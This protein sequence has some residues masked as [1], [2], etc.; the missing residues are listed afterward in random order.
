M[1][2]TCFVAVAL[3]C[4]A[5]SGC[6]GGS[7]ATPTLTL[8]SGNWDFAGASVSG[9]NFVIGGN[10][11]QSGSAISGTV[12]VINSTCFA[13]T[14]AVPVSGSISGQTATITSA[15]ITN[16]TIT[17]TL[18][19]S[20]SSLTGKYSVSGTGCA[21]GDSGT[22]SGVLVPSISGTW[23]GAFISSALGNPQVGVSAPI[24]EGAADSTGIFALSGS[25]AFSGSSCFST[26]TMAT[27][28][29]IAGRI[30]DVII[31]NNDGSTAEFVGTLTNPAAPTQMT[32]TYTVTGGLCDGDSGTGTLAKQ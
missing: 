26:G 31:K 14:T 3:L 7:G 8:T 17:A 12:R 30:T 24:T 6:G 22:L 32:G 15:S 13:T 11:T 28:S 19:G 25:A 23:T 2:S 20:A 9:T 18:S 4:F 1:R 5:F 29:A 27:G 10:V 21:A 16:Q